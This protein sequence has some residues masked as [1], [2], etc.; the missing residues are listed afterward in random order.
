MPRSRSS[1]GGGR[2]HSHAR[3]KG[4]SHDSQPRTPRRQRTDALTLEH[5]FQVPSQQ[6][7]PRKDN[8]S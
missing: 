3:K 6:D 2:S 7:N 1:L 8:H 5:M 4:P